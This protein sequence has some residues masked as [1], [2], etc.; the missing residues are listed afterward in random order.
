[1]IN[2]QIVY[3]LWE[4]NEN[5][6]AF[7]DRL[8]DGGE[9]FFDEKVSGEQLNASDEELRFAKNAS[10]KGKA[11]LADEHL[12]IALDI[13]AHPELPCTV[14]NEWTPVGLSLKKYYITKPLEEIR[15]NV[16]SFVEDVREAILLEVPQFA[17]CGGN[18]PS[19]EALDGYCG[20]EK[21]VSDDTH[22][23]FKDL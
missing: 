15:S 12:V 22:F 1:V 6:T 17:E 13:D 8:R 4:M 23:P 18:C 3:D 20:K 2:G 5:L 16:Y 11:Y 14:C 19:R 9:T 10:V 7:I 21:E